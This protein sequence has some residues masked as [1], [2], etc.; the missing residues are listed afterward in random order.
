MAAIWKRD[1]CY[2]YK[3]A[4][5][6]LKHFIRRSFNGFSALLGSLQWGETEV[7]CQNGTGTQALT[8]WASRKPNVNGYYKSCTSEKVW[9]WLQRSSKCF[10]WHTFLFSRKMRQS[11]CLL[12]QCRELQVQYWHALIISNT[13]SCANMFSYNKSKPTQKKLLEKTRLITIAD[14]HNVTYC[15]VN[16]LTA[17]TEILSA[18]QSG[19]CRQNTT[20][21]N[22]KYYWKPSGK[23]TPLSKIKTN[24]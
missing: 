4:V 20:G 21:H 18:K 5:M 2:N 10:W 1:T 12:E 22:T 23:L 19:Q 17:L 6:K 14:K 9:S 11:K 24:Y 15:T 3:I 13:Y 7:G 16:H 8:C